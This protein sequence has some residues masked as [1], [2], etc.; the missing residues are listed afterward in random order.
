[1]VTRPFPQ[2]TIQRAS[3]VAYDLEGQREAAAELAECPALAAP[4]RDWLAQR[5]KGL[6]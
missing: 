1:L 3:Q 5:L 6:R 2:W 4:W